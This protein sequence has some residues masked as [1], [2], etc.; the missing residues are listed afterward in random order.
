MVLTATVTYDIVRSI[1]KCGVREFMEERA[2]VMLSS[3]SLAAQPFSRAFT[4]A[5][6]PARRRGE[7]AGCTGVRG[8]GEGST[9]FRGVKHAFTLPSI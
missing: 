2:K 7:G 3:Q 6:G 4:E 1:G 5:L 8:L 9:A